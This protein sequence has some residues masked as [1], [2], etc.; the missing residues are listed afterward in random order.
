MIMSRCIMLAGALA[1]F[2]HDLANAAPVKRKGRPKAVAPAKPRI[3]N[4]DM[5]VN[6]LFANFY[7]GEEQFADCGPKDF[8]NLA[9]AMNLN[10]DTLRTERGEFESSEEYAGRVEKLAGVM[11]G[12]SIV[13]CE[14]LNDNEDAPFAYDA[15]GQ[16][17]RGSFQDHHNVWRDGKSLGTYRGKTRMGITFNV[18]ASVDIESDVSLAFDKKWSNCLGEGYSNTYFVPV[19][20]EDAP[21]TKAV[22]KIAYVARLVPPYV[23]YTETP[24]Q[25]SLDDPYDVYTHNVKVSARLEKVMI[26]GAGGKVLWTCRIGALQPLQDPKPIGKEADW[27][28]ILDYPTEGYRQR[29]SGTVIAELQVDE[30]GAPASCTVVTSSGS[31]LLDNASCNGWRKR[32][33]F[34]PASDADGNPTLGRFTVR[35]T[36]NSYGY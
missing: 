35:K 36:W 14:R 23:T 9:L 24:G 7:T 26:V 17:F 31:E 32:A 5:L 3:S 20:R 22:G 25:A 19:V 18:K 16:L 11:A 29:L 15:D 1:L 21:L 4:T 8:H 33:T 27:I 6:L 12:K 13:I 2:G 34:I 10:R 30:K 28:S